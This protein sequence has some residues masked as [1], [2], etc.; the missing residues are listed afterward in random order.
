[1]L[2]NPEEINFNNVEK[3]QTTCIFFLPAKYLIAFYTP[4]NDSGG[5]IW[6]HV[7]YPCVRPSDNLSK[8][9]WIF[10]KLGVCIDIMK[11]WFGIVNGQIL[12]ISDRV[13]SV[14][15]FKDDNVST[16]QWIFT[17]LDVCIDIVAT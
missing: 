3:N 11:L 12:S 10:T 6:Y 13:M 8:C 5:A 2:L 4:T 15:S 1:M 14:F 16:Y 7:G 17:K 9:Q